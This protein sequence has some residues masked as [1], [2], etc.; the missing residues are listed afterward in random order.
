MFSQTQ[1]DTILLKDVNIIAKV[2]KTPAG[3]SYNIIDSTVISDF[4]GSTLGELLNTNSAV[5]IK[6]YGQGGISTSSFRGTSASHTKVNFNGIEINNPMLGQF[7]FSLFP[8][9][10]IDKIILYQGGSSMHADEGA[11]GGSINMEIKPK[12]NENFYGEIN[13]SYGSFLTFKTGIKT[14]F[15]NNIFQSEIRLYNES[16]ENDFEYLNT[17]NGLWNIEK[18]KNAEYCKKGILINNNIIPSK[19]QKLNIVFWHLNNKSNLPPLMSYEGTEKE[20]N[21]IDKNTFVSGNW[22]WFIKKLKLEYNPGYSNTILH[23]YSGEKETNVTYIESES[24]TNSFYNNLKINWFDKNVDI[25]SKLFYN[26]HYANYNNLLDSSGYNANTVETG[27]SIELIYNLSNKLSSYGIIQENTRNFEIV[28]PAFTTGIEYKI[29]KKRNI[30]LHSNFSR[31]YRYPSLNDLYWT[32]GG[33]PDLLP[34]ESY[35]GDLGIEKETVKNNFNISLA[36]TCYISKYNNLIS[37]VPYD[38]ILWSPVNINKVNSGGFE[39]TVKSKYDLLKTKLELMSTYSL[40]RS[41]NNSENNKYNFS[42][43]NQTPYIPIHSGNIHIKLIYDKYY[44]KLSHIYTGKRSTLINSGSDSYILPSINLDNIRIGGD[45][46]ISKNN[47][48]IYFCINNILNVDYQ[49]I[50]W[51]AMPRRNYSINLKFCW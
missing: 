1:K 47:F 23:Y 43:E 38:G 26:Q 49:M 7:N 29:S 42:I 15:S 22:N 50:L 16:S 21:Q 10:F 13:Q 6:S 36:L 28:L 3:L 34:E 8:V 14:G 2:N 27:F 39:F 40:T 51:R 5:F 48:E 31:N 44:L 20:E 33:N 12:I 32:P 4:S 30:K 19:N 24:S 46:T 41:V 17:A 11:L 18:Q 35:S 37:W 9:F 45:F 25:K